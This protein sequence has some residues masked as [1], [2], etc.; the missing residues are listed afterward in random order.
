MQKAGRDVRTK[1]RALQKWHA[2]VD[3]SAD[4][5]ETY[6]FCGDIRDS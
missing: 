5:S 3:L 2:V 6:D 1:D 4:D